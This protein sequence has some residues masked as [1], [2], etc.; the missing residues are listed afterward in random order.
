M[1]APQVRDAAK[2]AAPQGKAE[3]PERWPLGQNLRD[4][5]QAAQGAGLRR[6]AQVYPQACPRFLWTSQEKRPPP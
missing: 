5:F 2:M 6:S 3:K 1:A 4:F